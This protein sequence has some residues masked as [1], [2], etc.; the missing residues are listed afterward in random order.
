MAILTFTGIRAQWLLPLS[1]LCACQAGQGSGSAAGPL[2][3]RDCRGASDFGSSPT[4]PETFDL[5]PAYFAGESIEGISKGRKDNRLIIRLQRSGKRLDINDVLAF[6]IVDTRIVAKCVR[7]ALLPQ[8]GGGTSPDYDT[9]NCFWGAA[10]P[11]V[12][13]GPN[14]PIHSNL[15]PLVTCVRNVVGTAVSQDASSGNWDS[16]IEFQQF[17]HAAQSG[18]LP[19]ARTPITES[20]KV[21]FGERLHA[22]KFKLTLKD[23]RDVKAGSTGKPGDVEGNLE[24]WFDFDLERGQGAQAFP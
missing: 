7:G 15:V 9:A 14:Q 13:I 21:D 16:W 8:P 11:R 3:I 20:F 24:G 4:A 6:D 2:Y 5:K 19:E 23:D 1:L 17:G 10:G 22:T 12:R 18:L